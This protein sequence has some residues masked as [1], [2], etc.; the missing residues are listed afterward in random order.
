MKAREGIAG[1]EQRFLSVC[2]GVKDEDEKKSIL[3]LAS[4]ALLEHQT[5][6]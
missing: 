1:H 5:I 2:G 6:L 3:D 4:Y